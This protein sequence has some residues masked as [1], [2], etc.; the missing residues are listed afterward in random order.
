MTL[1]VSE[2]ITSSAVTHVTLAHN[3]A[4]TEPDQSTVVV[5]TWKWEQGDHW[6]VENCL[7]GSVFI[8]EGVLTCS[9]ITRPSFEA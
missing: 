7:S 3:T 8:L 5:A 6:W 1:E 9:I 4:L 2:P